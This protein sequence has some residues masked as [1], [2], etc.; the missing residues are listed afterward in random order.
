M[1]GDTSKGGTSTPAA[2][3][4][5][6][7]STP[8]SAG[9]GA[10]PK[11]VTEERATQLARE[12]AEAAAETTLRKAQGLVDAGSARIE[13]KI[14]QEL[15]QLNA[16]AERMKA[17]GKEIPA[18]DLEAARQKIMADNYI[19]AGT[20]KPPPAPGTPAPASQP[21]DE[22]AEPDGVTTL[23]WNRIEQA[24]IDLKAAVAAGDPDL[25][26]LD[27]ETKDPVKFMASVDAF[28]AKKAAGGG[29]TQLA[30]D[31]VDP[32][33]RMPS[34]GGGGAGGS[35]TSLPD[36]LSPLEYMDMGYAKV[37]PN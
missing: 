34:M 26:L 21:G 5:P 19:E 4:P 36:G 3:Q 33:L 25:G 23:A 27:T 1:A 8:G 29:T 18:A 14:G 15:S 30:G 31:G 9:E 2:G 13:Q 16:A 22:T 20:P 11:Y 37:K 7:A 6:T 32:R 28:I 17:I 10:Q 35:P 12:A 24:G